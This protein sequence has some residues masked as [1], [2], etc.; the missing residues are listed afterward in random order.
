M[1]LMM[2]HKIYFDGKMWLIIPKL[3]LL[4]LLIWSS[5]LF[6]M[7]YLSEWYVPI[8]KKKVLLNINYKFL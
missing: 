1:V 6:Y 3:S 2:G 7:I 5:A 8:E 4:L